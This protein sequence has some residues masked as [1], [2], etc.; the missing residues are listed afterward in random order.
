MN[1]KSRP[2]K[3]SYS[4]AIGICGLLI[5]ILIVMNNTS[6]EDLDASHGLVRAPTAVWNGGS[7]GKW[8]GRINKVKWRESRRIQRFV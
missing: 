4:T 1:F 3:P 7:R 2:C 6:A 8:I 5:I